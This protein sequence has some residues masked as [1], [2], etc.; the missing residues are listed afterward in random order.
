MKLKKNPIKGEVR[1]GY[2]YNL[3][4]ILMKMDISLLE[5]KIYQIDESFLQ[6]TNLY[7]SKIK[8]NYEK[9]NRKTRW[10][11]LAIIDKYPFFLDATIPSEVE[12]KN[13]LKKYI[14][15]R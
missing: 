13:K 2:E 8:V 5:K 10:E 4:W 15:G 11:E 1:K 3:I 12:M 6:Y 7:F 14:K 9:N